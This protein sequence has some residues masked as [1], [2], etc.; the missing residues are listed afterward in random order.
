MASRALGEKHIRVRSSYHHRSFWVRG[1]EPT[2]QAMKDRARV[3]FGAAG[4]KAW[5]FRREFSATFGQS[6]HVETLCVMNNKPNGR[7]YIAPY[8]I[9]T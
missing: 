3:T 5:R 9:S 2:G 1:G 6:V 4:H 7:H 8:S